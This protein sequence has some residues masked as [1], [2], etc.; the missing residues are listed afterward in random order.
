MIFDFNTDFRYKNESID[1]VENF[2][3]T[4]EIYN[5]FISFLSDKDYEYSTITEE[6]L[7][8][9]KEITLEEGTSELLEQNYLYF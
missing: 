2:E 4:N 7:D 3:I 6:A 1:K 8:I 9:F 5:D